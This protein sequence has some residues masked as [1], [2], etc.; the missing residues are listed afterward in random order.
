MSTAL[1]RGFGAWAGPERRRS[2]DVV[3]Y[4]IVGPTTLLRSARE[5]PEQSLDGDYP[6]RDE[7]MEVVEYD[8]DR[9][10]N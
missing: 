8:I 5:W 1:P 2:H 3:S 10:L 7:M 9:A 6:D 4:V